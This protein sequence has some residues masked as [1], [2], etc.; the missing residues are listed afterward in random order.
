M[1]DKDALSK[2]KSKES[3]TSK[4][5]SASPLIFILVIF[6]IIVIGLFFFKDKIFKKKSTNLS[7]MKQNSEPE[8]TE[9]EAVTEPEATEINDKFAELNN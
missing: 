6:S 8:K 2:T 3:I 5:V 7:D 1:M 4:S 9:I